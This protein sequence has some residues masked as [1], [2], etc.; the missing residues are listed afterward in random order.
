MFLVI[1]SSDT[2]AVVSVLFSKS[3]SILFKCLSS[4]IIE[5]DLIIKLNLYFQYNSF[6]RH[7]QIS[8]QSGQRDGD[9]FW[10]LSQS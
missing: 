9:A 10:P 4:S 2:V 6:P 5:S 3:F 8:E 7:G 1:K